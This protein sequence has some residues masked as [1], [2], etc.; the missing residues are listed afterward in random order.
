MP[1]NSDWFMVEIDFFPRGGRTLKIALV[2]LTSVD[3]LNIYALI[4]MP[5]GVPLLA[6]ILELSG[7]SVDCFVEAIQRFKWQKLAGYD[8][9]GFSIISCTS[10]PTYTMIRKLRRAG[11]RGTIVVGGPHAT[12][13]P[14]ESLGAGADV[15]VR[16]EGDKTFSKLAGAIERKESLEGVPGITWKQGDNIRH[17]VDQA[18][19]TE[20]ELSTLPFPAFKNIIGYQR[21]RQIPITFS[22]GCPYACDFCAVRAMFG[23][24]YRFASVDWRIAQLEIFRQEY[25]KFW[26]DCIIFF[27][28]DNFFGNPQ[29]RLI[30]IEM[31]E[32]MIALDLIPPKGWLCQMRV[33][34]ATPEVT[35]LMKQAGCVIVCLGIESADADTLMFFHKG[36]TPEQIKAGLANLHGYGINTLAM[37]IAGADTDTFWSFF[38][39]IRWLLKWGITYLQVVAMVPL[40]GTEMVRRLAAEGRKLSLNLDR[41]NGMHV[42]I[43]PKRMSK[44]GVWLSLYFVTVWFYFLTSHGRRLFGKH[45]QGYLGMI[46]IAIRQFLKWSWQVVKE[47]FVHH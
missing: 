11:Y 42:L 5:R 6:A 40:P 14:E 34:D 46:G 36:Q 39:G 4:K 15:V 24:R 19:L 12:V 17:N 29:G 10:I 21:M 35:K 23:P 33:T 26:Q 28:D 41:Y 27:A 3:Y 9:V 37:T 22:R 18:L 8:L 20:E 45:P 25:P 44:V 32:R 7:H 1:K 43:K 30:A 16:H 47:R 2:E 38:R 31:L 13:L